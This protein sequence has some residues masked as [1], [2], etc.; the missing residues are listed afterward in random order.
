MTM[1][2]AYLVADLGVGGIQSMVDALGR[3]LDTS[4][5]QP[6]F[7]C[8]DAKG[9][10][11]DRLERDR[12]PVRFVPRRPG[13][14]RALPGAL[15]RVFAELGA[16]VVHAHN[17]TALFYSVL[18]RGL[19]PS[20]KLVYTEHD[21]SFPEVL[22]VRLLHAVLSRRLD[23]VAAVCG[24]VRDAIVATEHFPAAR[25]RV[26]VNGIADPEPPSDRAAL[27][28]AVRAEFGVPAGR[29]LVL[30]IGHL[31]PVKDH[32]TLLAAVA[33]IPVAARPHLVIAGDGPLRGELEAQR[34]R[35]QLGADVTFAGY[36]ND[37]SRLLFGCELLVMSSVSEGLSIALIEGAARGVP[38]VATRVGG[39]AEV[40]GDRDTAG[41]LLVPAGDPGALAEAIVS[42][43]SNPAAAQRYGAAGRA[44]FE[45]HFRL[46]T[47][48]ERYQ[49]LYSAVVA[50]T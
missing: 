30:A 10:L 2:I 36:R 15:A 7:I 35:L 41:G 42:I 37:V 6:S 14:D 27:R 22:K 1:R 40:V 9:A 20:P 44:R 31:T 13:F 18:A 38:I 25:T 24:V 39:N 45:A 43:L 17:K 4:R 21:R 50:A 26:I 8:F 49:S 11:Y 28:A 19:R 23:A 47:M 48:V 29:S 33:R 16:D 3:G 34:A 12:F 5:F 32:A 46:A